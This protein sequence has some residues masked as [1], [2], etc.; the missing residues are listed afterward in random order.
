MR[1]FFKVE[2]LLKPPLIIDNF[3]VKILNAFCIFSHLVVAH[4]FILFSFNSEAQQSEYSPSLTPPASTSSLKVNTLNNSLKG[5]LRFENIQYAKTLPEAPQL[6]QSN[7]LSAQFSSFSSYSK[8]PNILWG[9]DFTAGTFFKNNQSN[10]SIKEL[11]ATYKLTSDSSVHVGRKFV[12]WSELDSVW[13][14]GL[15]QPNYALDLLRPEPQGLVGAFFE[16]SWGPSQIILFGSPLFIPTIGPD[17]REEDG[18]LVSDSRWYRRPSSKFNFNSRINSISYN[19][20]T[21]LQELTSKASLGGLYQLGDKKAGSWIVGSAAYK[22]MNDV[23]LRRQNFKSISTD[24]INAKVSPDAAYHRLASFDLGYTSGG[25]KAFVG[26]VEDLPEEKRPQGE[27]I[28]QKAL[29]LK[30][31]S[32]NVDYEFPSLFTRRLKTRLGYLRI[33]GGGIVDIQADG[34]NDNFT[35]F[36]ERMKFKD[37]LSFQLQ[38]PLLHLQEKTLI[39]QISYLHDFAQKGTI[40][41]TEL[42][43]YPAPAWGLIVGADVLGV[44]VEDESS[45]FLNQYRANDRFYGGLNYVF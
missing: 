4:F 17:V 11:Y 15:W 21:N 44:E 23:I 20:N 9:F 1:E 38:G 29:P 41:G 43:F 12:E 25:T 36:D 33:Q 42:Q 27:W 8:N 5:V 45:G 40:V 39:A 13:K 24:V 31:Y 6:N 26:Y 28:T 10:Y 16:Q 3:R 2:V 37:A 30:A 32:L 19:L 22:P 34:T 14:L 18:N 7:Y 35:L